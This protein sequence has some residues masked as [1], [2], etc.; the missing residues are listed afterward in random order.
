MYSCNTEIPIDLPR[1][2]YTGCIVRSQMRKKHIPPAYP[3]SALDPSLTYS[4]I[5]GVLG[6]TPVCYNQDTNPFQGQSVAPHSLH[7]VS[8]S[9]K[10]S[11]VSKFLLHLCRSDEYHPMR[12]RGMSYLNPVIFSRGFCALSRP[13]W[14]DVAYTP[15]TT[16]VTNAVTLGSLIP[17]Q[18]T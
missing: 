10:F 11:R 6:E 5:R 8:R 17:A 7:D 15:L 16:A 12:R 13:R 2:I 3:L 14:P 18:K 9:S 1:E 4:E